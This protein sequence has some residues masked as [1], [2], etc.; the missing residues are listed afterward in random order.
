M[1]FSRSAAG[2][3]WIDLFFDVFIEAIRLEQQ[4]RMHCSLKS[5]TIGASGTTSRF[6]EP[7][8]MSQK[9]N[10]EKIDDLHAIVLYKVTISL[11]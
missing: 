7:L 5:K 1:R 8:I 3:Q 4:L 11:I 9:E 6:V 2:R 10:N